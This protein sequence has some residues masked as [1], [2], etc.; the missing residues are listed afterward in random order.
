MLCRLNKMVFML[1]ILDINN[2]PDCWRK[3]LQ[4]EWRQSY[5]LNLEQFLCKEYQNHEIF[6]KK[7]HIFSALK[8]TPFHQVRV[9]IVG[10]DPYH[11]VGQAH[12]LSFSV[13]ENIT[14]PPSLVNIF[15]ELQQDLGVHNHSG[16][17]ESWAKQGVLLLNTVLTVRSGSAASHAAK[18]WEQ[19]TDVIISKLVN[20]RNHLIFV[21]WGSFAK[22]KCNILFQ[23]KH[24]HAILAAPHPSPLSAYRG[25]LGCGHF[26]KINYLLQTLNEPLIEWKIP[27]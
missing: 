2:L 1:S 7:E 27:S 8:Y 17:L 19:L 15:K 20:R 26:S 18:G 21:L 23:T 9:V 10:Q 25:F 4:D 5:M 6:P 22:K 14:L 13:P 24:N 12:G 16:N 3:E 11:G